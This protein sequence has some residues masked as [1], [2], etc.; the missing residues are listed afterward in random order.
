M[1]EEHHNE[2]EPTTAQKL[3]QTVEEVALNGLPE[4]TTKIKELFTSTP[5]EQIGYMLVN[6]A[7]PAIKRKRLFWRVTKS[8]F[9]RPDITLTQPNGEDE[10]LINT[11]FSQIVSDEKETLYPMHM[12]LKDLT[13]YLALPVREDKLTDNE[14]VEWRAGTQDALRIIGKEIGT[15]DVLANKMAKAYK[16]N[17]LSVSRITLATGVVDFLAS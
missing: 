15:D 7:P 9:V 14:R 1:E 4:D 16:Q 17:Q 3:S 8:M 13:G 2:G 5:P 6:E 11:D 12:R 10:K